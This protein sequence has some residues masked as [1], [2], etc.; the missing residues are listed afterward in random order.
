MGAH[1]PFG[2]IRYRDG[3]ARV[4]YTREL[5]ARLL[6]LLE[7]MRAAR[8]AAV[9]HRNHTQVR[10][11][12]RCAFHD[13]C[14]EALSMAESGMEREVAPFCWPSSVYQVNRSCDFLSSR[15][16]SKL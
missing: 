11:C 13:L 9:V 12:A 15:V 14:D 4:E 10:R 3:E 16:P 6:R 2:I 1:V 5:R 8:T 7:E